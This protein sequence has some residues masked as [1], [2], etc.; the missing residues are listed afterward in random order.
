MNDTITSPPSESLAVQK[1]SRAILIALLFPT[2]AIIL[3]GS[4]FAVAL[5]TVRDEFGITADVAA[6]L[7]IAFSLPF[8]GLMPLFGRLGDDLGR[9]RLLI[10]GV[11]IFVVGAILAAV[12]DSLILIFIGRVIQGAGS[13][14]ITPL[15][16]AII[17]QRYS[18]QERGRALGTWNSIAPGTSVFAPSIGGFLVD[19]LGWR[20][21]FIPAILVGIFAVLVVR[22]QIPTLR[23]KPNWPVLVHFD[24][25]GVLL[26]SSTV[27]FLVLFVSSR[28]VTG[29]EPLQDWRLLAVLILSA[30]GF[31]VWERRHQQPLID[32]RIF[33]RSA[34]RLASVSAGARMAMMSGIGFLLPLYLADNYG[35]NASSIGVLATAHSVALFVTI[36]FGSPLADRYSNRWLVTISLLSQVVV[37][38]YLAILPAGRNLLWIV[39]GS[40][41]HGLGAGLS[42]AALHRTALGEIPERQTGSAAGIYSMTRF[43]GSMMSTALAGVI[44]QS[45]LDR[46]LSVIDAYQN[47]YWSLALIGLLGALVAF[48]MRE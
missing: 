7:T 14:G 39:G 10:A 30:G 8:M 36:R 47:V 26:L 40:I 22:W 34:F 37:M 11:I 20:A 18:V 32:L 4:M 48:R 5:P 33:R 1:R 42:L 25:G 3:S 19:S 28:P 2:M 41:M 21:I 17:S 43:A 16:L 24:W 9:A 15:S 31:I 27:L 38:G 12:A 46:G 45:G 6:W 29:V 35:L 13:A 44:L 23:G